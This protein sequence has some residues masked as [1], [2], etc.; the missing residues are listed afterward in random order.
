MAAARHELSR[1]E[2]AVASAG[3]GP[4]GIGG[5]P[6]RRAVQPD[7]RPDSHAAQQ[8]VAA[9]YFG[10]GPDNRAVEHRAIPDPRA[11]PD[12]ARRHAGTRTDADPVEEHRAL[13]GGAGT[14]DAPRA[15]RGTAGKLGRRV[16]GS[17]R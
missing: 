3:P 17:A 10:T 16:G 9:A 7:A 11:S 15:D 8:L 14:D 5:E 1:G 13:D 4:S 2:R 12:D 6:D